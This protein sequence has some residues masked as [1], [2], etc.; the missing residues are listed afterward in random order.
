M[1]VSSVCVP[2]RGMHVSGKQHS[3]G[4]SLYHASH[5]ILSSVPPCPVKTGKVVWRPS[6]VWLT[7]LPRQMARQSLRYKDILAV[8]EDHTR[9]WHSQTKR[10]L[11]HHPQLTGEQQ[12]EKIKNLKQNLVTEFYKRKENRAMTTGS[13]QVPP[14]VIKQGESHAHGELTDCSKETQPD[15]RNLVNTASLSV[16]MS[17][18]RSQDAR[19]EVS[20]KLKSKVKI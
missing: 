18:W 14:F 17:E 12:S 20:N 10:S 2:V 15:D 11:R 6:G 7:L 4:M 9:G 19:S 13:Y 16:R 8:S 5:F 1:V 3:E